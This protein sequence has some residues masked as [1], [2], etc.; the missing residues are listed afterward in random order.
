[1][2]QELI[3]HPDQPV[4]AVSRRVNVPLPLASKY[5]RA[6]NAR[7]LLQA[8]RAGGWVYYRA[9]ADKSVP[10]AASLLRA[11]EDTFATEEQ[12]I[13]LIFRQVT[14][15]TDPRRLA[16]VC[17]LQGG[18][19]RKGKLRMR[20]GISKTALA[21][22]LEKLE[23]RGFVVVDG[24]TCRCACPEGRLARTLLDAVCTE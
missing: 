16:I 11:L 20:T 2:L 17:L 14:A 15:F 18:E 5:L 22:H 24:F 10:A 12:P 23:D 8:R 4:S 6:L 13:E 7:G 3:R 21:R 19:M 9:S 1:M